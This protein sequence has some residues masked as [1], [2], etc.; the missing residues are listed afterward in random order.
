MKKYLYK[1]IFL[2]IFFVIIFTSSSLFAQK[3]D[4]VENSKW[5]NLILMK[6]VNQR[7]GPFAF[8]DTYLEVE[9]GGRY[10]WLQL[11]GYVD[12]IDILNTSKSDKHGGNNY[13]VDIEPR[14]SLDYLFDKDFS[15]KALK[16]LYLAF[17]YYYSDEPKGKGLN[18][19]WMGIGSDIDIPYLGLSGVNFYT[20]YIDENYGAS[21][22]H[23]F[24]GYVAHINWFKP[25]YFFTQNRFISF[26]GYL[27]YEFG[28]DLDENSFER[29]YRTSDSLQSYLGLYL[30]NK[31]WLIGYGLKAYKNMTQWKDNEILNDKKTDSTG[32]G[33]Y[34]S[35]AY[36]F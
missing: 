3:P 16:E 6:G 36:K 12:F 32:Y 10:E 31:S 4:G 5:A 22:E 30:H 13:F 35:I 34:F 27:D 33:H 24:D 18:V 29:Q 8:D 7:G 2:N 15:Y 21:N 9:F 19:L 11:Y 25:L 20:R 23:K 26:Q 17:D 28:S 14:I 1:S